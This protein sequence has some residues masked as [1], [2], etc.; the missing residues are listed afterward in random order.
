MMLGFAGRIIAFVMEM[1]IGE[2]ICYAII[3][4][5]CEIFGGMHG[6]N[7]HFYSFDI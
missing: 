6:F 4:M 7:A 1:M 5:N 3:D 2:G